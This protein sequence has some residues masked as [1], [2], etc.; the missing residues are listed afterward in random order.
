M[1]RT[2]FAGLLCLT[3]CHYTS[4][5]SE[6]ETE[7]YIIENER[8]W[9]ESVATGDT[10]ALERFIADDFVGVD[11]KGNVYDKAE[12]IADTKEAPKHF[13]SNHLNQVKVKF[14]GDTAIA[15]GDETWERRSGEPKR[16]RFVW[17]DTWMRRNGKWQIV[18][19][20]DVNAPEKSP[21]P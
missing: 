7:K 19:A 20:V 9:A 5:E 3:L 17:I 8:Q 16:G 21:T 2:L 18:A 11:P 13:I 6:S 12:M 14:H 15:Q 10:S 4:G 1:K